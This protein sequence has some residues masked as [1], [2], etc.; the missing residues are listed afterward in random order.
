M[1]EMRK[2]ME[3]IEKLN[4]EISEQELLREL[5]SDL[6]ALSNKAVQIKFL[7]SEMPGTEEGARIAQEVER[8]CDRLRKLIHSKL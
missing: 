1:N 3:T 5:R 4:E 7:F 6:Y 2:L 8:E